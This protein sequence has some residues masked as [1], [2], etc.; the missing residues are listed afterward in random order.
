MSFD[1][2][3]VALALKLIKKRGQIIIYTS[4]VQGAYDPAT[5][6]ATTAQTAYTIKGIVSDFNRA[7]DG[8]AF[9]S[10]LVLEGDKKILLAA[11]SLPFVP[12]PGD[13]VAWDTFAMTV[14]TVKSTS[15][16]E[17]DAVFDL[18]VRT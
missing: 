2:K 17:L 13:R 15:A 9:L 7:Q 1:T 5:G 14:Q 12:K 11:A 3:M 4:V 6:G 16:G 8:M 18:R 10:S